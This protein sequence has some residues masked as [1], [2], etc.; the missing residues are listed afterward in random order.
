MAKLVVIS[1]G[2]SASSHEL[3]E[4]WITIGRADGNNFQIAAASVS[5][6]HCEALLRGEELVVRDLQSTNGTFVNGQ[7]MRRVVLTDGTN[8]TLGRTTM[9]FHQDNR[10]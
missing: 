1:K 7:P 3:S 4:K 8:V 9:V 5:G 10:Y 2:L 6:R